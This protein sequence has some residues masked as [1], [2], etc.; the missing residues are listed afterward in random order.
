[1][2]A[3]TY[4][5]QTSYNRYNMS[6]HNLDWGNV[7]ALYKNYP[8][9][10]C[11]A[12]QPAKTSPDISLKQVFEINGSDDRQTAVNFENLSMILALA[13]GITARRRHGAQT[14]CY[15]SAP[16]AGALYPCE[17]Y[18]AA[19]SMAGLPAG[20]YNYHVKK[21]SLVRLRPGA[22]VQQ[23]DDA[24]TAPVGECPAVSFV[25]AGIFFRSAWKYRDRAFRYLLLD[26]GH[27]IENLVLALSALGYSYSVHYDFDDRS[28]ERILGIDNEREVCLGCIHLYDRKEQQQRSSTVPRNEGPDA[29]G[30]LA[31]ASRVSAAEVAYR[32]IGDICDSGRTIRPVEIQDR[33]A[34][35]VFENSTREWFPVRCAGLPAEGQ[36]Y[37]ESVLQRRSR[38]NFVPCPIQTAHMMQLMEA[39]C[40]TRDAAKDEGELYA[41]CMT[42]G[43]A[44]VNIEGFDPGVYQL[45][46]EKGE[47][48]LIPGKSFSGHLVAKVCL[49]Q[50]WLKNGAVHFVF[51]A[52]LSD[53]DRYHGARGYRYAMLNAGRAGQRI[54]LTAT[55]QGNGACG[56]GA[57]YDDE[58]REM[59]GLNSD[60]ALLYLVAVGRTR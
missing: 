60:S 47:Y 28:M 1:M 43:F 26:A 48:G 57:L 42:T 32:P 55:A 41:R 29:T 30:T 31:A 25:I 23:I 24:L 46:K 18:V 38:R 53:I 34:G 9:L 39:L 44:A 27:L 3:T 10:P 37:V 13:Y 11:V 19:D 58:A 14:Y 17:V 16:S 45:D 12:L 40:M 8:Q 4:H 49:G 6:P 36:D 51:M 52:N 33:G 35:D 5:K 59:L 56:I 2:N 7:P 20:L 54:Y 15:R 22:W 50:E 21:S